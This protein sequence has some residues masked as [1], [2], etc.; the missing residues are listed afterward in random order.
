[1]LKATVDNAK[2]YKINTSDLLKLSESWDIQKIGNSEFHGLVNSK[3]INILINRI[4]DSHK[5]IQLT[6]NGQVHSIE[7]EDKY[8]LLLNELGIDSSAAM[9]VAN[10]KAPMP[11]MVLEILVESGKKVS[12]GETVLILEA[13]KMENIIKSPGE[14][15]VKE[16]KIATG[17][18]VE[19]GE[20]LLSFEK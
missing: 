3:S 7:I 18:T 15:I 4:D 8:D 1:M 13:M 17:D 12:E 2:E 19:K 20:V 9:K 6:I 10:I 16:V 5:H 14:G 11:G